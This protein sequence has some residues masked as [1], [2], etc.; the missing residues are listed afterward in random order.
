MPLHRVYVGAAS[1]LKAG[2]TVALSAAQAHHVGVVLRAPPVI[3]AFNGLDG[4]WRCTVERSSARRVMV[5]AV[6]RECEQSFDPARGGPLLAIVPPRQPARSRW[7]VE[8]A[9]ELGASHLVVLSSARMQ[10][11]E[12]DAASFSEKALAWAVD[13]AQ[14]CGRLSVPSLSSGGALAEFINAWVAPLLAPPR[15]PP[16]DGGSDGAAAASARQRARSAIA[17]LTVPGG[18]QVPFDSLSSVPTVTSNAAGLLLVADED[19]SDGCCVHIRSALDQWAR[20]ANGSGILT[21]LIGPEGGWSVEERAAFRACAEL[22]RV[23]AAEGS[24]AAVCGG[25]LQRVT[26]GS[27][28]L[29]AETAALVALVH[30]FCRVP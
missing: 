20:R 12:F 11:G 23:A 4:A 3:L 16:F 19:S 1:R 21:I 7:V 17:A 8:K 13:A 24:N 2:A 22:A 28:T 27:T 5:H 6:S 18:A 14:Q 30:A 26:L 29:R 10:G 9:T 25:A 15:Q